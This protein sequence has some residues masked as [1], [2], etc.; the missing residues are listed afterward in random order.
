M[1]ETLS[2]VALQLA[3]VPG[4]VEANLDAAGISLGE[5]PRDEGTPTIACLPELWS[6][7]H[8]GSHSPVD[9]RF[10][11]WAE[12]VTGPTVTGAASLARER[13]IAMIVPFYERTEHDEYYNSA[14]VVDAGGLVQGVYR[15]VHLSHS[16]NGCEKYY[17]RPGSDLPVFELFGW[18]IG[19]QICYDR[20]FP[21]PSRLLAEAGAD[22]LFYPTSTSLSR[23]ELWRSVLQTRAF[24]NQVYAVGVSAA[25]TDPTGRY[26]LLGSSL[27]VGP[28]GAVAGALAADE[29]GSLI[30]QAS[31]DD[32]KKARLGRF[33]RR[34]RRPDVYRLTR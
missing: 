23:A 29:T 7:G 19:V 17:M 20:D 11:D 24:E 2:L 4:D 16:K 13:G 26:Q 30:R 27:I 9:D 1:S 32:L 22:I 10:F 5:L 21:E 14:A 3:S 8:F 34:D 33:L 6:T 18:R 28:D 15:K 12:P 25:G 31:R